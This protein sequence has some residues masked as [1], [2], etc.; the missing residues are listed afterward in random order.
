MPFF[1]IAENVVDTRSG[2]VNE[3]VG[4]QVEGLGELDASD[5]LNEPVIL[6]SLSVSIEARVVGEELF[7]EGLGEV[8]LLSCT[9]FICE[10]VWKNDLYIVSGLT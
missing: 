5:F 2:F 10:S 3:V 7:F 4:N 6:Q 9:D 1:V 8:Q